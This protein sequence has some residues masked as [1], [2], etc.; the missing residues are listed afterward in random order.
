MKISS[1]ART[2]S[3]P[4]YSASVP[5]LSERSTCSSCGEAGRAEIMRSGSTLIGVA[6]QSCDSARALERVFRSDGEHLHLELIG[7]LPLGAQAPVLRQAVFHPQPI[8]QLGFVALQ[9]EGSRGNP[10]RFLLR[11]QKTELAEHGEL[12]ADLE[13]AHRGD[14]VAVLIRRDPRPAGGGSGHLPPVNV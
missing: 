9:G 1:C 5:G 14:A 10:P 2:L 7:I 4:T 8:V 3:W 11:P 13:T 12:R 6:M